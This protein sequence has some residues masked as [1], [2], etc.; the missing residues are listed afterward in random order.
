MAKQSKTDEIKVT[1][2]TAGSHSHSR[3]QKWVGAVISV[4]ILAVAL[5][6]LHHELSDLKAESI[7]EHIKSLPFSA[8]A[9]AMVCAAGSYAILTGY[10]ALALRYIGHKLAYRQAAQTAF[11]AFAVGHNVG[12]AALSGGSVRY[13]MYSLLGLSGLEIAKV[14][15]FASVTF[16][17]GAAL[18][19]GLAL[20]LMPAAETA[21]LNLSPVLLNT[22][23]FLLMAVP[24]VYLLIAAFS[25]TPVTIR[26][27]MFSFPS[28]AIGLAQVGLSVCDLAFAAATLYVLLAPELQIGFFPFLGIYL[29]ALAAGLLSSVPGGL[30][31]F[32]A[33]LLVALPGVDRGNLL[34]TV[35]VYRLIYYV[36]PLCL[37]LLL[38]AMNEIRQHRQ[39]LLDSTLKAGGWLSA[40]VPGVVSVAVFLAGVVL[41]ISGATPAV[42]SR[43]NFIAQGVPL[44]VMEL[45]HLAGSV[46]G[47]G[48]LVLARGLSRRLRGAYLAALL[49]LGAGIV[50]SLLKGLD[51]EEAIILSLILGFLWV[52]RDEFYR[53]GSVVT[54]ALTIGWMGSIALALC[55]VVWVGLVSFRHV[56]YSNELW[57]QF[58]LHAD[59]SRMLRASL[60]AG[61]TLM[62]LVLWKLLHLT[63]SLPSSDTDSSE[64]ERVRK[65]VSQATDPS[66]NA[67]LLGDKKFLWSASMQSF[68]MYQVSGSSWVA[69]GDP[70]GPESE[71]EDLAWS[72]VEMVDRYDGHPVFY[73]VS[74]RTLSLYVD[75]GLSLVK[76]GEDARVSLE[77]FSLEGSKFAE[78]RQALNK[79]RKQ[80]AS[81]EVVP[82]PGVSAIAADLHAL[83]DS[84]L[85]A[86]STGEKGFSLGSFSE[87]YICQFDCAVVRV[88]GSIVAFANLWAAPAGGE[89]SVDLMRYGHDAPNYVMDYLFTEL[90]LWGKSQDYQWF[91]L[92]MAPLSGLEQHPQAPLWNKFGH[93]LFNHGENFYNFEGLRNYK[94]KFHPQWQ[95]RYLACPEGLLSLPRTLLDTSRLI[96]GGMKQLLT[97]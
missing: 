26:K 69:M 1:T 49:V 63:R 12:V 80:G 33:V 75:M 45:S 35:I 91:D 53:R 19:L 97:K 95:P 93:L 44:P 61:L 79:A 14:I 39:L 47:V 20:L 7:L 87:S 92:G 62:S 29:I 21:V 94:K 28:P 4:V 66:A 10:D 55:F 13:R 6:F 51:F 57:W 78:F 41:L 82:G 74:G 36:A 60:L 43:L 96:S 5:W 48:L 46:L 30:G 52:S 2:T 31:V 84:W 70:V 34:G 59:A 24:L 8:L 90:M 83:S 23:G 18:L 81:F 3:I 40:I 67:A 15:V 11:M 86:K 58:A 73:Q 42:S 27:W 38:L 72:F 50:V 89:L 88:Q 54:Q 9:A 56:D 37:A 71:W 32:E 22:T 25:R 68:I 64:I 65:V 85:E 77:S 17:L 76:L 16:A